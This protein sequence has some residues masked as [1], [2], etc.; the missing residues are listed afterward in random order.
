MHVRHPDDRRGGAHHQRAPVAGTDPLHHEPR[1]G[2]LRA[3]QQRIR[4][5]VP[6]DRR[7]TEHRA[8]DA[9]AHR[10]RRT[11]SRPAGLHWRIRAPARRCRAEL[12]LPRLRRG[13]GC[14]HLLHHRHH[15]QSQGRLFHPSPAGAAYPG[16][17]G[18]RQRAGEPAADGFGRCLHA[19]H[20]DVPRAC[21][22]AAV[23][24]HHAWP[25]AG[26]SGALRS[27]VPHRAVAPRAGDLLPLR[28]DHRA[29]AAQ[30]QGGA[31]YGFQRLEDHHRWQRADPWALRYRPGARDGADRRLRYV[32]DLPADFRCAH[33][34]RAARRR[35][36]NPQQLPAQ[37]RG[38]GGAGGRGDPGAGRQLPS[39]RRRVAGR[40][41]P[42]CALAD[43]GLLQR[44]GKE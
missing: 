36:G 12:R 10:W 42:A 17:R 34:R 6:G 11:G 37:G 29:D 38:A 8:E 1:R 28:A 23:R 22:G 3:G 18:H 9:A 14:D 2:P 32:R 5:A 7:A 40:V 41:G 26:L 39:G 35:R 19:D 16:R 44:A 43:P 4:A 27:G 13:L 15:R 33:Q 31:G 25:E 20:A 30:R 24:G 21:L